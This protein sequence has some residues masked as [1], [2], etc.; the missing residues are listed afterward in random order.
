MLLTLLLL[1]LL[2]SSAP[3]RVVTVSS[4]AHNMIKA[5]RFTDVNMKEGY[6]AWQSYAQSKL[7]NVMFSRELAKRLKGRF[8]RTGD[9]Y[10]YIFGLAL[11]TTGCVS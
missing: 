6:T 4:M 2:V 9:I 3:S 7:A 11:N 8:C 1:D 10:I 5:I